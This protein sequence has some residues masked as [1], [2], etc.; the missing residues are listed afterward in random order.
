MSTTSQ[1]CET[2]REIITQPTRGVAGIADD[3]LA[4]CDE[5]NLEIDWSA[6]R[7][8]VRS[9]ANQ[10]E[11]LMDASIRKSVFRAIL[12]RFAALCNDQTPGAVSP[13]GGEGQIKFGGD[14]ARTFH[15]AIT[16]TSAEQRLELT[17]GETY[18]A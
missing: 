6:D 12:A 5:H 9:A 17:C 15:F 16:N 1:I 14:P 13:Y 7:L 11:E 4:L 3:L 2:L 18:G 8:R 10:W